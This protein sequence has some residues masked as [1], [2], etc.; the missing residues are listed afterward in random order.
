VGIRQALSWR[1]LVPW[2]V[3]L[4]LAW[5]IGM[6]LVGI[7]GS[8]NLVW[9]DAHQYGHAPLPGTAVVHL[10]A[11]SVEV[12]V[13]TDVVGRGNTD[14]DLPVPDGMSLTLTPVADGARAPQVVEDLGSSGNA[15]LRG[16]NTERRIWTA[17]VARAGDYTATSTGDFTGIGVDTELWFGHGPP[18]RGGLVPAYGALVAVVGVGLAGL[19]L[20]LRRNR[21][22]A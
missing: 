20:L 3:A 17:H 14:V 2:V 5:M 6:V 7:L 19:V 12:A 1:V 18:V 9:G 15:D 10:P 22:P 11:G 16:L 4:V 21:R 13:A 8:S